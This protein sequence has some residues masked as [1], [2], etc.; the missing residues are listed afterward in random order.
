MD[1][2]CIVGQECEILHL[3]LAMRAVL[4][5][6]GRQRPASLDFCAFVKLSAFAEG[7][8]VRRLIESGES[9]QHDQ[10]PAVIAG[11]KMRILFRAV[12]FMTDSDG[13]VLAALIALRDTTGEVLLQAKYHKLKQMVAERDGTITILEEKLKRIR[14]TFRK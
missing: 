13:R 8:P 14:D 7:C 2:L 9:V 10:T 4:G 3:N 5:I 11:H 6:K 12:P 1:P